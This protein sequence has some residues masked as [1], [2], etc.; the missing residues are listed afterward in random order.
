MSVPGF[1]FF[2]TIRLNSKIRY[3]WIYILALLIVSYA[4]PAK[5]LWKKLALWKRIGQINFNMTFTYKA[6]TGLL[7]NIYVGHTKEVNNKSIRLV[8][9]WRSKSRDLIPVAIL[10]LYEGSSLYRLNSLTKTQPRVS[11]QRGVII[12]RNGPELTGSEQVNSG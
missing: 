8:L 4:R 3:I 6:L 7:W 5:Q 2:Q 12:Y 11:S 1:T 10:L 9:R